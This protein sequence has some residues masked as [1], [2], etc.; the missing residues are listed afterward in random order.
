[1]LFLGLLKHQ[2][3]ALQS[4]T[5]YSTSFSPPKGKKAL[6]F[7]LSVRLDFSMNIYKGR[8]VRGESRYMVIWKSGVEFPKKGLLHCQMV[9]KVKKNIDQEKAIGFVN[10]K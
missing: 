1:M 6:K 8:R 10:E 4:E 2:H 5:L 9:L 3:M 7:F